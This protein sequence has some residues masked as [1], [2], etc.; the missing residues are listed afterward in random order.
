MD[1]PQLDMRQRGQYLAGLFESD[2]QVTY[3]NVTV[4][5]DWK[6]GGPFYRFEVAY[7]PN[8]SRHVAFTNL[9]A[10]AVGDNVSKWIREFERM[11]TKFLVA[12]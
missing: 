9:Q 5:H 7:G 3:P 2:L 8:L 6:P 1:L 4:K 12:R 10:G 11:F